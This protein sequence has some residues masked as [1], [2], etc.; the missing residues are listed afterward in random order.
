MYRKVH[1]IITQMALILVL[2]SRICYLWFI[3][4]IDQKDQQ[5]H[6]YP[7]YMVSK[8]TL[9]HIKFNNKQTQL[10]KLHCEFLTLTME[11]VSD[12]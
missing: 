1:G 12:Q 5:I 11:N 2:A 3:L 8:Y 7:D 10:S 6:L 4:N 9:W